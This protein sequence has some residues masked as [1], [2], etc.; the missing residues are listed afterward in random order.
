[1]QRRGF[2]RGRAG[3][4]CDR[5]GAAVVEGAGLPEVLDLRRPREASR[6]RLTAARQRCRCASPPTGRCTQRGPLA[7]EKSAVAAAVVAGLTS[8][9]W[10]RPWA[11][12]DGDE[13]T[14]ERE[15]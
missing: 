4:T 12:I 5:V 6:G 11:H 8:E 13:C 10:V 7:A 15:A 2:E 3:V 1:M 14:A 9:S